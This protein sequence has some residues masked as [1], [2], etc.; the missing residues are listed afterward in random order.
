MDMLAAAEDVSVNSE[1]GAAQATKR[2]N[3][4]C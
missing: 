3:K 2:A 1:A 4:N